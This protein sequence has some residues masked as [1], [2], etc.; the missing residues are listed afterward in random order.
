M[1]S[2]GQPVVCNFLGLTRTI[3]IDTK[4]KLRISAQSTLVNDNVKFFEQKILI[5]DKKMLGYSKF[6][7]IKWSIRMK[8]MPKH[9]KRRIFTEIT[10]LIC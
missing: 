10:L 8:E 2:S 4:L 3:S 9:Y 7:Q 1:N 6:G 5:I